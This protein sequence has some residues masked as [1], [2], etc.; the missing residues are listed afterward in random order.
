[1][2][3]KQVRTSDLTGVELADADVVTVVVKA[4]PDL[5]EGKVFDASAA[6]LKGITAITNLVTLEYRYPSG[7]TKQVVCSKADFS[8][9]VSDEVL[10][11]A[12]SSRGRRTGYRPA[13]NGGT[14]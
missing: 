12:D 9:V 6:E 13:A 7:D 14:T 3:F 5:T 2:G 4:H 1:M 11:K 10:A 8:K